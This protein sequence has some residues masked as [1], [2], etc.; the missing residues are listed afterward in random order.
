MIFQSF[1]AL[2]VRSR[3]KKHQIWHKNEEEQA[4]FTCLLKTHVFLHSVP[5]IHFSG[6]CFATS[7]NSKV[8][9]HNT[10][11][12]LAVVHYILNQKKKKLMKNSSFSKILYSYLAVSFHS[13]SPSSLQVSSSISE[14]K[15]W[16][17]WEFSSFWSSPNINCT[18]CAGG[19]TVNKIM[20]AKY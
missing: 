13:V 7:C 5:A 6:T 9:F 11:N 15:G 16:G 4:S 3:L 18:L 10:T 8:N 19:V 14:N 20:W 12:A 1:Q 2:S 17:W